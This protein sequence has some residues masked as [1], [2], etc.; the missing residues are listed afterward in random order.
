VYAYMHDP[1][2]LKEEMGISEQKDATAESGP[3]NESKLGD[4][5]SVLTSRDRQ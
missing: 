3:V 5:V 4:G 2:K 1:F